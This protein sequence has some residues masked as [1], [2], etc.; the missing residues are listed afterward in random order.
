M[1]KATGTFQVAS[2][3]EDEYAA[4]EGGGK[5]T[6]A[7]VTQAFS[8]DIEGDAS[9]EWLM[10]YRPDG[11]ADYTGLARVSGRLGDRAGDFVL[12]TA[13]TFD[14]GEARGDWTVVP[15]SGTGA[16]A[17][18]RGT[19]RF[20]APHGPTASFVLEYDGLE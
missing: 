12:Q 7:S 20:E 18:L 6:R 19:G 10:C 17:N 3:Q 16:L 9:V 2:W 15:G 13:G 11:T 4:L 5:L 8:G 14:G 1:T